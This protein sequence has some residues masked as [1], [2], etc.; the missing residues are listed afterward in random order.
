MQNTRWLG[1]TLTYLEGHICQLAV[2]ILFLL[3]ENRREEYNDPRFL[4]C[5]FPESFLRNKSTL[6]DLPVHNF[7]LHPRAV[8]HSAVPKKRSH[9]C[10]WIIGHPSARSYHV[11]PKLSLRN[12]ILTVL[13]RCTNGF[14]VV[15]LFCYSGTHLLASLNIFHC[16]SHWAMQCTSISVRFSIIMQAYLEYI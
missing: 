13:C 9:W 10:H 15:C 16:P 3:R 7:I 2:E 6:T 11:I 1:D 12:I 14:Y 8:F 4:V 5:L